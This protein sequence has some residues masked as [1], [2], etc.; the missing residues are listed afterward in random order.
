MTESEILDRNTGQCLSEGEMIAYLGTSISDK[1]R[2]ILELHLSDC[3]FCSDALEGLEQLPSDR[4]LQGILQELELPE[5]RD[6]TEVT[7]R[8]RILFPW[9]IAAAFLLVGLSIATLFL[10]KPNTDSGIAEAP[11]LQPENPNE[12]TF[13]TPKTEIDFAHTAG[14]NPSESEPVPM[15]SVVTSEMQP[16]TD[17]QTNIG[18]SSED[19][20]AL[21]EEE[22]PQEADYNAVVLTTPTTKDNRE[23]TTD[24]QA[25]S[26][27]VKQHGTR[28]VEV[29]ETLASATKKSPSSL[30]ESNDYEKGIRAYEA[31]QFKTCSDLLSRNEV[32]R[33]PSVRENALM[34]LAQCQLN[35]GDTAAARSSLAQVIRIKGRFQTA[36]ERQLELLK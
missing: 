27:E 8:I 10:L 4:N 26:A 32:L 30:K 1:A 13:P 6:T 35:T 31:G 36:A 22:A 11:K 19:I 28:S 23:S 9:R 12:K 25:G 18:V 34:T 5:F 29:S 14:S 16:S 17:A 7:P 3:P 24:I 33:N 20:K 2:H 15:K 21:S